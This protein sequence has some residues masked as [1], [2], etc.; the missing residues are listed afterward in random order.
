MMGNKI[1]VITV[2]YN[3]VNNIRETMESFFSQSWEDKEY[4]VIDGG[5][6]DG[7]AEIIKEY[8]DRL[9]Y[10]CSEP[11]KGIYDAMNKGISHITGNWVNFLNCGDAY[12]TEKSLEDAILQ[13]RDYD[14]LYGNSIEKD[15]NKRKLIYASKNTSLLEFSPTFR[16]GSCIIKAH[17]QKEETFDLAKQKELGYALDWEM[18]YRLYKKGYKFGKV[19]VDIEIYQKDGVSNHPIKNLWYNYKIT[20][21]GNFNLKKMFFFLKATSSALLKKSIL[22]IYLRAFLLEYIVNDILPLI[23]FWI[24]RKTYL[25]M[26]GMNI[27]KGSFIMKNTYIHNSNKISIGNHSHINR[28]CTLDGRGGIEIKNNVSISCGA[29]LITGGH[30]VQS[31][32]FIGVF[33]PIIID[34][35]AWIGYG[36]IILQGVHIGEG[37]VV[38]AGAVVT[39]DVKPYNIVAGIPA[40]EKGKRNNNLSYHCHWD[41]PLT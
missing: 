22:Y 16:H 31:S 12:V 35:Y 25:K 33:K 38:C 24:L 10:W 26:I 5:S 37:A 14:V 18:L 23:P 36:A 40:K 29:S 20:S 30:D 8:A 1:S 19:D 32:D 15:E 34:D 2:V 39:H 21:R 28:K 3:D 11:D 9:A 27:E 13:A 7:T 41:T 4:I 17:I 6:T